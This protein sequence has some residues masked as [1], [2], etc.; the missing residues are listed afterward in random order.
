MTDNPPEEPPPSPE[1]RRLRRWGWGL[2]IATGVFL[3]VQ[4]IVVPIILNYVLV[5]VWLLGNIAQL[6][7]VL[8]QR[9]RRSGPTQRH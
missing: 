3:I 9:K 4:A 2:W 6:I 5:A 8:R 1:T 7:V